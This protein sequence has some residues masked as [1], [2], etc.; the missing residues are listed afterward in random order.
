MR[1]RK[2]RDIPARDLLA[3]GL[4]LAAVVIAGF[5]IAAQFIQPAP[6]TR[7]AFAS[8][9][10][11]GSYQQFAARYKQVLA[12]FGIT[13]EERPSAGSAEN[14][15]LLLDPSAPVAAGFVQGGTSG[16]TSTM[17]L[18]SLG[19]AYYEPVWVFYRGKPGF[20]RLEDLAGRRLAIGPEGS[21]TRRLALELLD[22]HG[23]TQPRARLLPLAGLAAAEALK[24]GK[25]DAVFMVGGLYSAGVWV[26]LHAEGISLLSFEQAEAYV[27]R[28]PDLSSL[29]LPR[30]A[31]S[32][33]RDIPPRDVRLIAP[34]ATVV[35]RE[36]IH[37]AL[38]DLLLQAMRE[39]HR[40]P[41]LLARADEFPAPRGADFPLGDRAERFYRSGPPFLQRYLPFWVANFIDRAMV[42][43]LPVI[44]LLFPLARIG[45]QLY[46]WRVRSRVYRWYGELKHLELRAA[47]EPGGTA[48]WLAQLRRIEDEVDRIQIPLAF[49]DFAYTL[50]LHIAFVRERLVARLGKEGGTGE[51]AK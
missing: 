37:P 40:E 29:T 30:G 2:L 41:G 43:L 3:V 11:G 19:A 12:R 25:V 45:P 38:T 4:P 22:A 27:R 39:V 26:L 23:M 7:L 1:F 50:R 21:G 28:Y 14:L 44:A 13:L 34:M 20:T 33:A 51:D 8:G 42:M 6:P 18:R 35:V 47:S 49:A 48:Q 17:P 15:R 36:D 46:S 24:R 5:W 31:V 32:F 16:D 9:P 10:E